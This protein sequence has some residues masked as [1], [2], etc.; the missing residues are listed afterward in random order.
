MS[1]RDMFIMP[2]IANKVLSKPEVAIG[3]PGQ[4]EPTFKRSTS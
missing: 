2:W 3:R 1:Y 4:T